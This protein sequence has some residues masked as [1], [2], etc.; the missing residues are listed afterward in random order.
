M[1]G[2]VARAGL[3]GAIEAVED[4]GEFLLGNPR[5]AVG[6]LHHGARPSPPTST[7]TRPR[8]VNF[9]ALSTRFETSCRKQARVADYR[10]RAVV[11]ELQRE[12]LGV[13]AR[14]ASRA[15]FARNLGQRDRFL[16]NLVAPSRPWPASASR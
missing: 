8:S 2:T 6:D 16:R 5:A 15:R 7:S 1:P 9:T 12:V 11:A 14:L 3:V 10:R 13:G 4:V